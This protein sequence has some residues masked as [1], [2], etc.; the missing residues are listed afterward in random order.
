MWHF[1]KILCSFCMTELCSGKAGSGWNKGKSP[2]KKHPGFSC[3]STTLWVPVAKCPLNWFLMRQ[4]SACEE[5]SGKKGIRS[6]QDSL[7][8]HYC[9]IIVWGVALVLPS[10]I[11]FSDTF[12]I[13]Y[14]YVFW[15]IPLLEIST[16]HGFFLIKYQS[17]ALLPPNPCVIFFPLPTV[18]SGRVFWAGPW[19]DAQLPWIPAAQAEEG[20]I[21]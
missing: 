21:R 14:V 9:R 1:C 11:Y 13:T 2:Q 17:A 19:W 8:T 16:Y 7:F 20:I 5:N 3:F 6:M 10:S 15:L 18:L 4:L 12:I